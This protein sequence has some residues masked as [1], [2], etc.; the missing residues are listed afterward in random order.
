MVSKQ[1][2]LTLLEVLIAFGV[3]GVGLLAGSWV[4]VRSAQISEAA[5]V[6]TLI[7]LAGQSL[8]ERLRVESADPGPAVQAWQARVRQLLGE[9]AQGHASERA[10]RWILEARWFDEQAHVHRALTLGGQVAP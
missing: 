4:Q 5:R 10:G 9:G 2:G 6:E 8:L 3:L 7:V 1:T